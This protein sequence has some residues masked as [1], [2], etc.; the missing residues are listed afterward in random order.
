MEDRRHIA[1]QRQ[2]SFIAK[3]EAAELK[4]AETNDE[5]LRQSWRSLAESWRALAAQ[6]ERTAKLYREN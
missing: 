1:L 2:M 3:A 6:V 5:Q 4:M